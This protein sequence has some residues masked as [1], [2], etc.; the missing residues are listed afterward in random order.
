VGWVVLKPAH[1]A[2]R[3]TTNEMDDVEMDMIGGLK[4]TS[5]RLA[6]TAAGGLMVGGFA[7]TPAQAADLGGDC[8]ADLEERVAELEATAVRHANRRVTLT[9]SGQVNSAV[10]WWDN[11]EESD[12]YVIDNDEAS[13]RLRIAGSG[14]ITHG[15]T[16][17][18]TIEVDFLGNGTAENDQD[19]LAGFN[20]RRGS[21][22]ISSDRL[23]TLSVGQDSMASDGAFET[24]F[25]NSWVASVGYGLST[26]NMGTFQVFNTVNQT[27]TGITWFA[28]GSDQDSSRRNRVR[29]DSPTLAGFTFSAAWG[30]DDE[31]DTAL[32]YSNEWNGLR[33]AASVSYHEDMDD[34]GDRVTN[35]GI[36][37]CDGNGNS[38]GTGL[39]NDCLHADT[40]GGSIA[41]MHVPSGIHVQGGYSVRE[42]DR[43]TF[44]D[45]GGNSITLRDLEHWWIA[46]G[47]Q[48]R[49]NSLGMSEVA[50][51]YIENEGNNWSTVD[52]NGNVM[53]DAIDYTGYGI[54][55]TQ[56]IDA[57]GGTAYISYNRHEAEASAIA[58]AINGGVAL[59]AEFDQVTAGMRLR[60]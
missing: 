55:F 32:R 3:F 19:D 47:I 13:T 33:V 40:Y 48:F 9:L 57:V 20:V 37:D 29:Y 5:S 11:G 18:L 39:G 7:L 34:N 36:V 54:A 28:V 56:N 4:K 51:Q 27:Y 23:G 12:V 31:W 45:A 8:C 2:L 42:F 24:S 17:S 53:N 38:N 10:M 41:F 60:Y 26:T 35:N 30:E 43:F 25:A 22:A 44:N 49:A 14:Q 21:W 50:V 1:A 16:A 46:A 52:A 58:N 59:D 6:I 15:V